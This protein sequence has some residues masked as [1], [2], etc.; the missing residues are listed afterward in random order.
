[1][2]KVRIDDSN[3]RVNTNTMMSSMVVLDTTGEQLEPAIV[4]SSMTMVERSCRRQDA[5]LDDND[6]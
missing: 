1:M 4:R 3:T 5:Y 2:I 6:G